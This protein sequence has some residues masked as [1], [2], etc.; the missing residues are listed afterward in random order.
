MQSL[1]NKIQSSP[2]NV[3]QHAASFIDK[4]LLWKI[5]SLELNRVLGALLKDGDKGHSPHLEKH[6]SQSMWLGPRAA[7]AVLVPR[8]IISRERECYLQ[9]LS[10]RHYRSVMDTHYLQESQLFQ[11][12][13]LGVMKSRPTK[14]NYLL[15]DTE[16]FMGPGWNPRL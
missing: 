16:G 7:L 15:K 10:T 4:V 8:C 2:Q 6:R 5:M 14:I 1:G 11:P 3:S 13:V 9:L 12:Q